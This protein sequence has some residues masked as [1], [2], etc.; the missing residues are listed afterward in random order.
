M[1]HIRTSLPVPTQ[2]WESAKAKFLEG[3]SQEDVSRF[4][5]A[6]IENVF[7]S[8]EVAQRKHADESKIWPLQQRLSSLVDAIDDYGKALDV[9]ANTYGLILSPMWGSIRVIIHVSLASSLSSPFDVSV[10]LLCGEQYIMT[11]TKSPDC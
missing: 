2:P 7:Y 1:S 5:A 8:T 6:N 3:L 9:Y 10:L 4:Q 11:L